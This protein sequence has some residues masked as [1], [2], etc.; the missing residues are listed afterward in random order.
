MDQEKYSLLEHLKIL[1]CYLIRSICG[2]IICSILSLIFVDKILIY[3]CYPILNTF[4]DIAKFIVL[5]PQEYFFI[6]LKTCIISGMFLSSPWILFQIWLFIAPGLYRKEKRYSIVFVLAGIFFF[7]LGV[8]FCYIIVFPIVFNFFINTLPKE[9]EITYSI[10]ML[11]SFIIS[12]LLIFGFI[13]EVPVLIFLLVVFKVIDVKKLVKIRRYVFVTAFVIGALL[14]P[15][16]PITQLLLAF[17]II[18]LYEL[19][20]IAVKFLIINKKLTDQSN[21][22]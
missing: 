9:I 10:G 22:S 19:G 2:M 4:N 6:Q 21:L 20:L 17:P 7:T 1:R 3:L 5:T 18:F 11:F 16:D 8:L 12:M 13:F 14:T 15:P